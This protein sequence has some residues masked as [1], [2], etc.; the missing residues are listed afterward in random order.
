MTVQPNPADPGRPRRDREPV[1]GGLLS[2]DDWPER[3]GF[4]PDYADRF[5]L[6]TG[7]AASPR[8]WAAAIFEE[9]VDRSSRDLIFGRLLGMRTGP[10]G[11]AGHIAG[12][13]VESDGADHILLGARGG[14]TR[15]ALV[16]ET[17]PGA[18]S[19]TTALGFVSRRRA[20][21][22]S[23][24]GRVHRRVAAPT[25]RAGALILRRR[26]GGAAADR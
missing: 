10:D 13:R 19:L 20:I 12:W 3:L 21:I 25:L 1:Y 4:R 17:R 23:V 7:V 26:A 8:A 9:G 16:V 6:S 24:L 14:G 18:V 11:Q 2:R 15:G 5:T 22:W